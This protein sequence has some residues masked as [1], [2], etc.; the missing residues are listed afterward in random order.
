MTDP[1]DPKDIDPLGRFT[2]RPEDIRTVYV[3]SQHGPLVSLSLGREQARLLRT[4]RG[5]V[6]GLRRG[7][8]PGRDGPPD[9]RGPRLGAGAMIPKYPNIHIQLVGEDGNAFAILGR[10]LRAMR[11]AGLPDEE[12]EAFRTEATAGDYDALL[13]TVVRWVDAS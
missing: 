2:W 4:V 10:V 5:D 12:V 11:A 1:R 9:R 3:P 6:R 13:A 7:E 8:R